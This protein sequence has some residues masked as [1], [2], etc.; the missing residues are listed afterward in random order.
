VKL[1]FAACLLLSAALV[2]SICHAQSYRPARLEDGRVDLQGVWTLSNLTPLERLPGFD[3]LVIS[4]E[5][6]NEI[7]ERIAGMRRRQPTGAA[8]EEFD[9]EQQVEPIDGEWHSS[10]I[11]EPPDGRIPGNAAFQEQ[12]AGFRARMFTGGD[13]PEERAPAERCLSSPASTPPMQHVPTL[14]LH[15]IVQTPATLLIQSEWNRDARIVRM[16]AGHNPAA[17]TSWLGDSVG[18]WDG[19]TLVVETRHFSM[20]SR[21]RSTGGVYF[22]VSPATVVTER[23]T[24]T[25]ADELRY[26]FT[27]A[28][29][30]WYTTPWKG[31]SLLRRSRETIFEFACHEGN[32]AVRFVLQGL[33][34][35][36]AEATQ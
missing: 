21:E 30:T 19:D 17:V 15:Q 1:H 23:F 6:A 20:A 2:A 32:Y 26:E 36:E 18:W 8:S 16:N 3:S 13:G 29:P 14:N 28:D 34:A 11:V 12:F 7:E 33:R 5:Q 31:H 4:R 9:E 27:V 25:A 22:L 24:R 35:K 10:V